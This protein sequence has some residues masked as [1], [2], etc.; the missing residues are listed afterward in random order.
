MKKNGLDGARRVMVRL[1]LGL[2]IEMI[3]MITHLRMTYLLSFNR[4]VVEG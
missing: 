3:T 1:G 2:G 4:K